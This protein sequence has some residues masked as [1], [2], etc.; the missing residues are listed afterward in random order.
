MSCLA[1]LVSYQS[2]EE[3]YGY[4]HV[5]ARADGMPLLEEDWQAYN[6]TELVSL[7]VH[8]NEGESKLDDDRW[9]SENIDTSYDLSYDIEF[10]YG[11]NYLNWQV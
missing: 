9:I 5:L 11:T 8:N 6:T 3:G 7:H 4:Q 1:E 10:N 2:N